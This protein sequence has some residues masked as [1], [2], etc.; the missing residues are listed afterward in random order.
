MHA[1]RGQ[2][3]GGA[4]VNVQHLADAHALVHSCFHNDMLSFRTYLAR[5]SSYM[6][7]DGMSIPNKRM[8]FAVVTAQPLI[9]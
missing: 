4:P 5:L 8:K 2:D 7:R 9:S 6:M 3:A 1:K